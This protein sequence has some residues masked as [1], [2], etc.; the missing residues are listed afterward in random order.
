MK[1]S[2]KILSSLTIFAL[3]FNNTVYAASETVTESEG[4]PSKYIFIG[5]AAVVIILLLFLGYKMDTKGEDMFESKPVK[6]AEK[7]SVNKVKTKESQYKEDLDIPYE[8]DNIDSSKLNDEIEYSADEEESLFS[9]ENNDEGKVENEEINNNDYEADETYEDE[10]EGEEFDTS[11]IDGIEDEED[12]VIPRTEKNSK[13][14]DET[15]VFNNGTTSFTTNNNL[16]AEIDN[17]ENI[18]ESSDEINILNNNESDPF[19]EELKNF[20]EPESDFA[21]FSVTPS[22]NEVTEKKASKTYRKVKKPEILVDDE[23]DDA[24]ASNDFLSQME[25]N[26]QKKEKEKVAKKTTTKKSTT[27][28]KKKE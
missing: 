11:I 24:E 6:K 18:D 20:K 8:N 5:I 10:E 13:S 25:A 9:N 22:N 27:T 28:R 15:M 23:Y 19:I 1:K 21:G 3:V 7:K 26:L 2:S 14:F 4:I 12:I 17:L 16:E